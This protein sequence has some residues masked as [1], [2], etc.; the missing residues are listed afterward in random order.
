MDAVHDGGEAEAL[1]GPEGVSGKGGVP[2]AAAKGL[3]EHGA[4][5]RR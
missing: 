3:H 2:G 4:L 5:C 1:E